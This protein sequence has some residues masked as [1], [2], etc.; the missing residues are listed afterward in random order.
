MSA[1]TELRIVNI[2]GGTAH[3]AIPTYCRAVIAIKELLSEDNQL[4]KLSEKF[5]HLFTNA[6][7]SYKLQ[8]P[9]AKFIISQATATEALG[10][11]DS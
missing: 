8:E 3:N 2:N 5:N 4:S 1:T 9:D 7:S 10:F 11:S 6:H